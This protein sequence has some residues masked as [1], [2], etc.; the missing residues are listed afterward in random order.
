VRND[1]EHEARKVEIWSEEKKKSVT[2]LTNN[3]EL[4]V[5]DIAEIYRLRWAIESLYK[6]LKQN[7]P[8]HFFYGESVNAI[9]IQTWVVLIANL[10]VTICSRKIKRYCAFSQIVAMLSN[11]SDVLYR[12]HRFYGKS[13]RNMGNVAVAKQGQAAGRTVAFRLRGL[14]F[15][16][17]YPEPRFFWGSGLISY[18]F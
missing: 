3:F 17:S 14:T 11:L 7:F 6:Q 5:E 18:V 15:E 10:L 13:N 8:L 9:Q 4:A 1:L 16:K 2:L 12:F